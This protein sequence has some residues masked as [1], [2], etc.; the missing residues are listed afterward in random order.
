MGA[1]QNA[2]ARRHACLLSRAFFFA[3]I[4]FLAPVTQ[5]NFVVVWKLEIFRFDDADACE[6]R[7]NFN[8]F[9]YSPKIDTPESF[10]VV[11]SPEKSARLFLLKEVKP[12]PDRKMVKLL[13]FE[14]LSLPLRHSSE[15]RRKMA[16]ASTF[17][18]H[19]LTT[20]RKNL[21]LVVR[22]S[23]LRIKRS[24][25]FAVSQAQH[26]GTTRKFNEIFNLCP[27]GEDAR[28]FLT[29]SQVLV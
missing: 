2:R 25:S 22:R 24:P 16:T 15:T 14:N 23:R 27:Q 9:V 18:I 8:F 12:S 11:F 13:T 29:R 7:F 1:R 17:L 6:T 10:I 4:Y 3:P 28:K 20:D 5:A 19:T 21:I 26:Q